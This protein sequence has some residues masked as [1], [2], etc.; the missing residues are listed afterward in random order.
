MKF[1]SELKA[2]CAVNAA[3]LGAAFISGREAATFFAVTGWASWFGIAAAALLF[4]VMMGMLCHFGAV[5]GARTLPGIYYAKMDERCGDALS[6]VH[7]LMML[8]MGAVAITT[9][10]ELGMLSLSMEYPAL[11][12]AAVTVISAVMLTLRGMAPLSALGMLCVP[13][14]I[15][16]FAALALDPR[17]AGAGAFLENEL[18]DV[19]GNV[20]VAIFMGAMFAFLKSAVS[21][22]VAAARAG[23]LVPW[24]FGLI[25]GCLM[26]LTAGS[27]NWALQAAGPTVWP[28]NLPFVVLAARWGTTGYY[29]SVYIMWLGCTSVLSCAL[30]SMSSLFS[31]KLSRP[32]AVLITAAVAS[33]MSAAGLRP[34]VSVAYP[35]LGWICATC[36]LALAVFY[37]RKKPQMGRLDKKHTVGT[38]AGG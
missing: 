8:M 10:G 2:A 27:A 5:T 21:G 35:M 18:M 38:H 32:A 20:P 23:R 14:C 16:F 31:A 13:L 6:V 11:I 37:E 1:T 17:P 25:C 15:L 26:A 28:L 33:L 19:T 12:S 3:S 36:L 9:A 22:G 34:L 29:I 7:C 30:G 24:R 4:G